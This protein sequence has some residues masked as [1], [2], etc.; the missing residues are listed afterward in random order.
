[1]E[2]RAKFNLTQATVNWLLNLENY[3]D[4]DQE[5]LAEL[6]NHLDDQIEN[7]KHLGLSDEESFWIAAKRIGEPGLLKN[8]FGKVHDSNLSVKN[9]TLM[10]QGILLFLI[11]MKSIIL[12]SVLLAYVV[13]QFDLSNPVT[14][15]VAFI[16]MI[17]LPVTIFILLRD[18]YKRKSK[19]I[20]KAHYTIKLTL[21]LALLII[22]PGLS[23]YQPIYGEVES[24]TRLIMNS[25]IIQ[26]S[27]GAMIALGFPLYLYIKERKS[28]NSYA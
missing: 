11:G 6:Q 21:I 13:V 22:I 25:Q 12:L 19:L 7:L 17:A 2:S 27:F 5:H 15:I 26:F 8:E 1:M 4:F 16:S 9:I 28:K 20:F 3:G 10:I 23:Y 24:I 18:D 14:N